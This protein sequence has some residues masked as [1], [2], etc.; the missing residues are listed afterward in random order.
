[1]ALILK[2][3]SFQILEPLIFVVDIAMPEY[4]SGIANSLNLEGFCYAV[5][6]IVLKH[7]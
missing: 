2:S 5:V 7:A 1:M 3:N 4:P 6:K